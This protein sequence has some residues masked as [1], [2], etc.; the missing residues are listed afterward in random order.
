MCPVSA[1]EADASQPICI[2]RAKAIAC[3]ILHMRFPIVFTRSQVIH[4]FV[5]QEKLCSSGFFWGDHQWGVAS[6]VKLTINL[7]CFQ[8]VLLSSSRMRRSY[9]PE[10]AEDMHV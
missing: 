10:K 6:G 8:G 4:C 5:P 2:R 9:E 7:C 3:T 1:F